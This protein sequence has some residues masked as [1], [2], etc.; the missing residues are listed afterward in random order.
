MNHENRTTTVNMIF[1]HFGRNFIW[2]YTANEHEF[3]YSYQCIRE[4][5]LSYLPKFPAELLERNWE[6]KPSLTALHAPWR[7][8]F[9][10]TA[11]ELKIDFVNASVLPS[12]LQLQSAGTGPAQWAPPGLLQIPPTPSRRAKNWEP[13]HL[14]KHMDSIAGIPS[15]PNLTLS[16]LLCTGRP[17]WWAQSIP[18]KDSHSFTLSY[19]FH[20]SWNFTT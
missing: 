5:Q 3:Y 8:L 7:K 17:I 1:M 9:L 10:P 13:F 20:G 2:N 11:K 15:W 6:Q 18:E 14:L 16:K 19:I 4:D 12:L